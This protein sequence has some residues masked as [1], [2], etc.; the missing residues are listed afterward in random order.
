MLDLLEGNIVWVCVRN[1]HNSK[2]GQ[3]NGRNT[4]KRRIF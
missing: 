4:K 1:D 2:G 3:E